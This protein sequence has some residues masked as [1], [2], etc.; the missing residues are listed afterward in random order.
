MPV[1]RSWKHST[2]ASLAGLALA[3]VGLSHFTSP[4]LFD[5]ITKAGV[6]AQHTQARLHP[7]RH[8]DRDRARAEFGEDAAAGHRRADR[9]RGLLGR[10]RGA[11]PVATEQRE[12][13]QPLRRQCGSA[14]N[15]RSAPA[16]PR[17]S[18]APSRRARR[19]APARRPVRPDRGHHQLA[20]TIRRWPAA[21]CAGSSGRRAAML[22][23]SV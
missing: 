14:P 19:S 23:R 11:Q 17:R 13:E 6:S 20:P 8:R 7:R 2:A 1:N 18:P 22:S 3:A 9:L 5:G 21:G 15:S 10:Q 16:G 12:V 4:Q